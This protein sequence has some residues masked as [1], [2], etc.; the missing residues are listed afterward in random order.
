MSRRVQAAGVAAVLGGVLW[1]LIPAAWSQYPGLIRGLG[2]VPILLLAGV[3][4]I[5]RQSREK[6]A[7]VDFLFLGAGFVLL[8]ALALWNA[9][10]PGGTPFVAVFVLGLPALVALLLVGIGSVLLAYRLSVAES[11][12]RWGAVLF[13]VALPLDPLFNAL[14]TPILG[15]GVSL[16]GLA[17]VALGCS[18]LNTG[19][20]DDDGKTASVPS[21]TDHS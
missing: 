17:W 2:I 19:R 10:L 6:L 9:T 15:V 7:S 5:W 3:Y 20:T 21:A 18:L 4:G 14:V 16:Y 13:A 8:T 11:L 12:P 1:T